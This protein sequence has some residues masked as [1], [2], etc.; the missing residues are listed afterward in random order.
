MNAVVRTAALQR[1]GLATDSTVSD[2]K[3]A[4]YLENTE[5]FSDETFVKA[6][7]SLEKTSAWF[8]KCAELRAACITCQPQQKPVGRIV[9][10]PLS[11]ERSEFWLEKIRI[12]AGI[13]KHRVKP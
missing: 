12:A 4:V 5:T 2:E 3:L 10:A 1:L 9:F 11:Q 7:R 8:P 13:R 6:C